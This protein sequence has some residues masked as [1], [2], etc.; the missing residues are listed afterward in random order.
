MDESAIS[1]I[2]RTA[3]TAVGGVELP[4]DIP[5]RILP[6][7]YNIHNLEKY[8][9]QPSRFRGIFSTNQID[10]FVQYCVGTQKPVRCFIDQKEMKAKAYFDLGDP[11]KPGHGEHTALLSLERTAVYK[12][13]LELHQEELDQKKAAE[14][15]EDWRECIL[16]YDE[17][18]KSIEVKQGIMAIRKLTINAIAEAQHIQEDKRTAKST[19]ERIEAQNLRT[20]VNYFE[21]NCQPYGPQLGNYLF[22]VRVSLVFDRDRPL[23]RFNVIR[24]EDRKETLANDFKL[25]L[26]EALNDQVGDDK[27]IL[28]GAFAKQP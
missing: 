23:L 26:N 18:E 9:N 10:D 8:Q 3:V 4:T 12:A 27:Q 25:V 1:L 2:Q 6:D 16:L 24:L 11:D 7:G 17:N 21:F 19:L 15:F 5:A 22:T 28:I 14:F 13:L 20:F